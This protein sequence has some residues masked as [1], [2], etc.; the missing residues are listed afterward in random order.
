MDRTLNIP[1]NNYDYLFNFETRDGEDMTY[2]E[3]L[4]LMNI[5]RTIKANVERELPNLNVRQVV[6]AQ[7]Q[8]H[9]RF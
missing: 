4:T 1:A 7:A 9:E 2:D 8:S 3:H 5:A 6:V